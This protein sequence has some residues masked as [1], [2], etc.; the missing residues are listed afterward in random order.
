[1]RKTAVN[2]C[3]GKLWLHVG[4]STV[5]WLWRDLSYILHAD[6]TGKL[7]EY[8][9]HTQSWLEVL[10]SWDAEWTE[11]V[12]LCWILLSHSKERRG[13]WVLALYNLTLKELSL[14]FLCFSMSLSLICVCLLLMHALNALKAW[15]T[16][17]CYTVV[18]MLLMLLWLLTQCSFVINCFA[19]NFHPST[20]I[21]TY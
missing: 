1:M 10:C 6:Y 12:A 15:H 17:G 21:C 2:L 20:H 16:L 19:M 9:G 4:I 14:P 5:D 11:K 3:L 13:Q 18:L 7:T 8:T